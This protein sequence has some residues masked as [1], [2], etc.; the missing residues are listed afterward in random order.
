VS[1]VVVLSG[2]GDFWLGITEVKGT[3]TIDGKPAKGAQIIFKPLAKDAP[4]AIGVTDAQGA[5]R[6]SR[7][8]LGKK[9]GAAA[10]KYIVKLRSDDE[11]KGVSIPAKYAGEESGL[12]F[13][14]KGGSNVFDI[15][16]SSK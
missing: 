4:L 12:A 13:E 5:Y 11:G 8:G 3:V 16:I 1:S 6:L 10:G 15:D 14:V 2:C 7:I 9:P